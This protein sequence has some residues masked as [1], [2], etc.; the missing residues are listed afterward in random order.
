MRVKA[1]EEVARRVA[2]DLAA[3]GVADGTLLDSE[4]EMAARYAVGR[5]TVR[6]ALR[7]LETWGVIKMRVGR[8]GGPVVQHPNPTD[9]GDHLGVIMQFAGASLADL[10]DV[11]AV[12]DV[13]VAVLA[14]K[15]AT[16]EEVVALREAVEEMGRHVDDG[17]SYLELNARFFQLLGTASRNHALQVLLESVIA[18]S[19]RILQKLADQ[20][21]WRAL[22]VSLRHGIVDAIAEGDAVAA[23]ERMEQLRA[24]VKSWY[25]ELHEEAMLRPID[26]LSV[27]TP[28]ALDATSGPDYLRKIV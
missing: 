20:P 8:N 9:I 26:V 22:S 18:I 15:R 24:T 12:L 2:A 17:Q 1:Y 10:L 27:T 7:L 5:S 23:G 3:A 19:S 13:Q 16:P 14:A 11:R 28:L 4:T 25:E 21:T 6:E